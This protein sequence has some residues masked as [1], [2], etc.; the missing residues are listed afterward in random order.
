MI[1]QP[2]KITRNFSDVEVLPEELFGYDW[3]IFVNP[4]IVHVAQ[5]IRNKFGSV[6]INNSYWG[7]GFNLS[8]YRPQNTKI[9]ARYSQHKFGRAL[10]LKF[11]DTYQ[12]LE[13]QDYIMNNE[14]E[15]YQLG[16]R[17]MECAKVTRTWLHIDLMET[18]LHNKILIFKP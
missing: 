2:K 11:K 12:P 1:Y 3:G 13:V 4:R 17:R 14:K 8:G 15:F 16:L 18:R 5:E 6:T 7:G 9:G 10:D